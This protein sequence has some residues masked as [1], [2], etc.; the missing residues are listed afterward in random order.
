MNGPKK[1]EHLILLA[2]MSG[3]GKSSALKYLEDI[4]YL[5]ID[6]PPLGSIPS[7]VEDIAERGEEG[8]RHLAIGIH[9]RSQICLSSLKSIR[10]GIERLTFRLEMVYIEA[11]FERLVSRYRETRR[12]HPLADNR[13]V[14]E[15]IQLEANYLQDLRQSADF[16]IDTSDMS[17]HQ[18]KDRM[19]K[20]FQRD[21][22][23]VDMVLILRSFGF[24]YGM[25]TD[26]D[27]VLDG[28]FLPN[29]H[30]DPALRLLTGLDGPVRNFLDHD[31]E[32]RIFLDR[33]HSLFEYLIPCYIAEKKRYFTV[34]I[35]CTGGRHRSVYIVECLATLLKGMAGIRVMVQHQDMDRTVLQPSGD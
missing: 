3:A 29:P 28:R 11:N 6:N 8:S 24:K 27:M 9:V 1:I 10:E 13:T 34:D 18:L 14:R 30:Y 20:L 22:N 35:G 2:G 4:G 21:T 12:R 17:I 25:R 32:T 33:M 15:A 31:G 26:A 7:L 16:I 5:W 19:N 23:R